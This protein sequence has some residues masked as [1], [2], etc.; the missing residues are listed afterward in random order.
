MS[1]GSDADQ[2]KVKK[3]LDACLKEPANRVCAECSQKRPLWA[4]SNLGVFICIR[5]SG[6]HRNLGVHISKVKGVSLD[7]W[8]L[9]QAEFMAKIGNERANAHFEATMPEGRKP[10]E[11]DSTYTLETFIRDK[12]EK[13]L[14]VKQSGGGGGSSDH[15]KKK[16]SKKAASSSEESSSESSSD[17][18]SDEEERAAREKE[19][20][21]REREKKRKEKEAAAAAKAKAAAAAAA[22]E[23]SDDSSDEEARR[24]AKKAERKAAKEK[25]SKK[26]AKPVAIAA[27]VAAFDAMSINPTPAAAAAPADDGFGAFESSPAPVQPAASNGGFDSFFDEES[28]FASGN[29]PAAAAAAA[30]DPNSLAQFATDPFA[31]APAPKIPSKQATKNIMDMFGSGGSP[32]G[33][34]GGMG[35]MGG[36]NPMGMNPMNPMGAGGMNPMG[37][38]GMNPMNPMGGMMQ[39]GGFGAPAGRPNPMMAQPAMGNMGGFGQPSMPPAGGQTRRHAQTQTHEA[40]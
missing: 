32:M 28:T 7:N 40:A 29:N 35:G 6:I 33:G 1:R 10:T 11:N 23:D 21:K 14:W 26:D 39:P 38:G 12:Y 25:K 17:D 37:M 5:C 9:A 3:I 4:S 2:L 19:K 15:K 13:K 36:M 20:R 18:S 27:P 22:A 24:K 8:P 30:S 34:F 31:A 16:K